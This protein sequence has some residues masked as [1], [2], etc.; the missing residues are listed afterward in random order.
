MKTNNEFDEDGYGAVASAGDTAATSAKLVMPSRSIASLVSAV[1]AIG[2]S[3]RFSSRFCA[4]T[5]TSSSAPV[6]ASCC[7]CAAAS[8]AWTAAARVE[9]ARVETASTW[10]SEARI[11]ECMWNSPRMTS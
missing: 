5:M 11:C 9:A 7:P 1:I 8:G 10:P 3:C 4:V 2:V 6:R